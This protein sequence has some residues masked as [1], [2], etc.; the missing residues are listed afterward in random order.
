MFP[1]SETPLLL[2]VSEIGSGKSL[3]AERLHQTSL[4]IYQAKVS[5]PIP[6]YINSKTI[7][8]NSIEDEV[9]SLSKGLGNPRQ[10]GTFLVIDGID[11]L[12]ID[13]A[14]VIVSEV[15]VLV[16]TFPSTKAVI[17]SRELPG[18][19]KGEERIPIPKI[20][21]RYAHSLIGRIS[22]HDITPIYSHGWPASIKEAISRPLFAIILGTYLKDQQFGF[23]QSKGDL[24]ANLVRVSLGK[25][26][27]NAEQFLRKLA[28][29]SIERNGGPVHTSEVG[30]DTEINL[31]AETGIVSEVSGGL[32][33]SLPIFTE[34]FGS[35]CFHHNEIHSEELANDLKRL[36]LWKF[37]L[38]IF[39]ATANH[40][41]VTNVLRPIAHAQPAMAAMIVN[42]GLAQWGT[43]LSFNLPPYL[44]SGKRVRDAMLAWVE[45]CG[46]LAELIA[47]INSDGNL[48]PLGVKTDGPEL[49]TCW[50]KGKEEVEDI[51]EFQI[52]ICRPY[53]L[54]GGPPGPQSAWAWQRTLQDLRNNLEKLLN[55]RK[56]PIQPGPIYEEILWSTVQHVTNHGNLDMGVIKIEDVEAIL[57][58]YADVLKTADENTVIVLHR[59]HFSPQLLRLVHRRCTELR[60]AGIDMITSPWPGPDLDVRRGGHLSNVYTDEQLLKRTCEVYKGALMAYQQLVDTQFNKFKKHLHLSVI[61]PASLKGILIPYPDGQ[62][63]R[64]PSL[65]WY[66]DPLPIG[67]ENT[68]EITLGTTR[69]D[70]EL[71]HE[72]HV[73]LRR[74]RPKAANWIGGSFCD[75]YLDVYRT[76]SATELAYNWL[77]NDLREIKWVDGILSRQ[78]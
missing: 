7:G 75:Q 10:Q 34:W 28:Q 21:E 24:L 42:D 66:L 49:I 46:D 37:P 55:Q 38:S 61:L 15:R 77:F 69:L 22:G 19:T 32:M 1:T 33:F 62:I 26:D 35:Q 27:K 36:E 23:P 78:Y 17:T 18:L 25:T 11:E 51:F 8:D 71:I 47:P 31:I 59:K 2:L 20:D 74:L 76:N 39:V 16:A 29:L 63:N 57:T 44:E 13:R 3:I 4:S 67:Q 14:S 48:F 5:A 9:I 52:E 72:N 6:I 73:K 58:P 53:G 50:Y 40:N 30:I 43:S 60:D 64:E 65:S 45:G 12:G 68:I 56:I 41:I 54:R 70:Y